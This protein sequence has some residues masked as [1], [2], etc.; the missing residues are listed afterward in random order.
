MPVG[1]LHPAAGAQPVAVE[2]RAD[3]APVGEGDRGGPVP[4]LHQAGVEG[5]EALQVLGQVVA[6]AVGLGDHHHRRVR[7]RAAGEHQQLEHVVERRRVRVARADDRQDLREVLAEQLAAQLAL[8]GAHPVDVAHQRVDL[9]VVADHPVGV[10]ELPAGERV[11]REARVHERERAL[12]ALVAQVR[13]ERRQLVADQHALVVDRARGARGHVQARLLGGQLADAADHVQLALEGVLVAL[14]CA[15]DPAPTNSWRITGRQAPA[16]SPVCSGSNGHVAPA[17]QPL[18]LVAHHALE[19]PLQAPARGRVGRQ[20]AHQHAV[21]AGRRQLEVDHRPQQL[22]G[23][24][25]QD[26]GAVAG[27]AGPR[28]RRRGAR[29]SRAP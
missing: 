5:V 8:A 7:Q 15:V 1:R 16:T 2:R 12:G 29:G 6:V 14:A 13:V 17:E 9:A 19:Q 3:H 25:H 11:G 4:R 21:G 20:E 27:A 22:V 10:G 26:P 18:A 24:L 23:H 28:R